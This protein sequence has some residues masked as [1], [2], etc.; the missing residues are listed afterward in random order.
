MKNINEV[1]KSIKD[2]VENLVSA[3]NSGKS[4]RYIEYLKFCSKFYNYSQ[5]NQILIYTQMPTA[6]KVA[7]FKAW[8]SLGFKINKGSKAL[9]ILAPQQ[10]KYIEVD[11]ERIY[12]NQMTKEQKAHKALHRVGVTYKPVPVFDISQCTNMND[13]DV[14]TSF[15]YNLGDTHKDQYINLSNLVSERLNINIIETEKTHGAEGV[16]MGGTNLIKKSLDYNNK[17]LTL[18]HE[19]AHEML[20]K[21]SDSDREDTTKEIRELRAESISYIVGQYLGLENPFSSDYLLMYKA[22]AKSLK[23]HLDKIQKTSKSIIDL[24]SIEGSGNVVA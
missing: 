17:L 12:F 11:G 1:E 21:G 10:Y 13:K 6:T 8:E 15:F 18:L 3:L 4:E 22:D 9:K 19:I 23:D 20:D 14:V 16:S 24:L 5:N 2:A 7:G